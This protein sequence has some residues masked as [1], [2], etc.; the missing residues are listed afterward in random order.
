MEGPIEIDQEPPLGP[1][2]PPADPDVAMDGPP[3]PPPPSLPPP[4]DPAVAMDGPPE[5]P[6]PDPV[7]A[8][9][10]AA[11]E[12]VA[13]EGKAKKAK[14]AKKPAAILPRKCTACN[15][16]R[17]AEF[18]HPDLHVPICGACNS[19]LTESKKNE[20]H[21]A[22]TSGIPPLHQQHVQVVAQTDQNIS[23]CIWCGF[24][25]GSNLLM[26]DVSTKRNVIVCGAAPSQRDRGAN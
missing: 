26:C 22:D 15:R 18:C 8:T 5:L 21:E 12:R 25:D 2:P 9:I 17:D 13:Q 14:A 1:L 10:H 23:F 6:P 19:A 16:N 11:I 4:P 7:L 24:G 20:V 3:E